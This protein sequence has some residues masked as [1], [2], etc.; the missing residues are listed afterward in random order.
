MQMTANQTR[1]WTT[2]ALV[3]TA[4]C[5]GLQA[6]TVDSG[7]LLRQTESPS[8]QLP[9]TA[10]PQLDTAATVL[11][12]N[13]SGVV[14]TV[15]AFNFAGNQRLSAAQLSAVVA[16]YLN[17]P[18]SF[19]QL[20][21]VAA[22]VTAAYR[23]AGWVV[24]SYLPQ[25]DIST[26]TVT[27]Q[28]VEAVFGGVAFEAPE[29]QRVKPT[30]LSAIAEAAQAPGTPLEAGALDRALLLME[31]LPGISVSGRLVEGAQHGQ[32]NLVVAAKDKPLVTATISADNYGSL[33]TGANRLNASLTLNSPTGL[34]DVLT[35]SLMKTQGIDYE[36]M[37]YSLPVGASGAR[38]GVHMSQLD[39]RLVGDFASLNAYGSA[40]TKGLDFSY[41]LIRSQKKNLNLVLSYDAKTFDD[42]ASS[43]LKSRF[44]NALSTA[45]SGTHSDGYAGGG[46]NSASLSVVTGNL[47]FSGAGNQSADTS[48]AQTAGQY[49]KALFSL[50]RLQVLAGDLSL[51]VAGSLQVANKNLDSSEKLYLG[52]AGGVRAYPTAEGGG[53]EGR[54]VTVEIQKRL[55]A[56]WTLVGF[57]DY[58]W[59]K[60]MRNN[61]TATDPNQYA[62]QGVGASVNWQVNQ[63]VAAKATLAQRIGNNI[64]ALDSD[65]TKKVTRLWINTSI[66]F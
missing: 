11:T 31:D 32:T 41:P 40:Q 65:G 43:V 13:P 8:R 12:G 27:I 36:R 22:A 58:G 64:T 42:T 28:V 50:S 3:A 59:L 53:S 51:Y 25:Q 63:T 20:Q 62:L 35:T 48:T 34:G 4:Y 1:V 26:G 14:V 5:T 66:A 47:S 21:Q 56:A 49:S 7:S 23:D 17:Q 44:I 55:D 38:A 46:M 37:A 60:V 15:T 54:T 33:A 29:P 16:S 57:Y 24:R 2:L 45:L 52:G 39:Y 6:Q 10:A 61:Y 19:A 9:P 18:L 30:V